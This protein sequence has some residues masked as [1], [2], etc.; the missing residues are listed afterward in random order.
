MADAESGTQEASRG[1]LVTEVEDACNQ[2]DVALAAAFVCLDFL[3]EATTGVAH[4][5]V[6]DAE[7]ALRRVN[8]TIDT[9]RRSCARATTDDKRTRV[10]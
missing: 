6:S 8:A 9:L 2:I 10:G 3:Q 1:L 4:V 5:A 7:A